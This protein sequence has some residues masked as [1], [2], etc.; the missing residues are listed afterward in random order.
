MFTRLHSHNCIHNRTLL[1]FHSDQVSLYDATRR[2]SD[3]SLKVHED[4]IELQI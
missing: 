2:A 3:A 4:E 1:K